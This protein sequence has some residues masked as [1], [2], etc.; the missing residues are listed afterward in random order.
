MDEVEK[1]D[2]NQDIMNILKTGYSYNGKVPR[3]NSNTY[4]QEFFYTYS[5]KVFL[6]ERLPNNSARGFMDRTFA[7]TCI[8]GNPELSIKEVLQIHG[9]KGNQYQRELQEEI[10]ELRKSLFTFRL[11]HA[12]ENRL[13]VDIGLTN[14]DKELCEGLSLFY[15]SEVQREVEETFQYFLNQKYESKGNSFDYL[16]LSQINKLLSKSKD[17]ISISV[18]ELWESIMDSTDCVSVKE[19]AL[20]LVDYGFVL[21]Y[22][23]LSSLCKKFGAGIKHTKD[24]N[25]LQ[26]SASAKVRQAYQRYSQ[27]PTIK[28]SLVSHGEGDEGDEDSKELTSEVQDDKNTELNEPLST[29]T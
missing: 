12:Y 4:E 23:Q 10:L 15:G 7:I 19:N 11:T 3:V 1:I 26:F 25:L 18:K 27:K 17:K 20:S 13:E 28:C 9:K 2:T 14:R 16:L 8:I 29:P 22:N 5:F 21:Y 24:G 6:S